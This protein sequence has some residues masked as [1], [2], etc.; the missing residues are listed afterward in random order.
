[1][2]LALSAAD[3]L[4]KNRGIPALYHVPFGGAEA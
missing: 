3:D 4:P 1:M 2:I